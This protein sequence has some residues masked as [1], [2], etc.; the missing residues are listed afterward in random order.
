MGKI[1]GVMIDWNDEKATKIEDPAS[2]GTDSNEQRGV[3]EIPSRA[4]QTP[5]EAVNFT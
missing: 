2:R 4:S 1:L 5:P 3:G